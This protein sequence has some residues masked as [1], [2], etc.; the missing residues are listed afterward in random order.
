MDNMI[1][2][3]CFSLATEALKK[4]LAEFNNPDVVQAIMDAKEAGTRPFP[5]PHRM[6]SHILLLFLF[7]S[8]SRRE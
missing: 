8:W 2:W 6:V 3:H 4:I 1:K 5:C 7:S